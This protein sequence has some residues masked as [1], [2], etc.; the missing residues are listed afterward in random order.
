MLIVF[1]NARALPVGIQDCG[2][3]VRTDIVGRD[4]NVIF[5]CADTHIDTVEVQ[6]RYFKV[7]IG[8][9]NNGIALAA[10]GTADIV[11]HTVCLVHSAVGQ[12]RRAGVG[13]IVAGKEE[14]N[15]SRLNGLRQHF[16]IG[17]SAA[18]GIR[19]VYRNMG[20]NN[21]PGA[22][23]GGSIRDQPLLKALKTSLIHRVVQNGHINITVLYRVPVSGQI[24]DPLGGNSIV[25]VV[26]RLV[27]ADDMEEI[28]SGEAIKTEQVQGVFPFVVHTNVIDRVTQL[29]AE[30]VIVVADQ[31]GD[32]AE[33][34]DGILFLNISHQEEISL[35]VICRCGC[36]RPDLRPD[37]TIADLII[38]SGIGG[39][40]GHIHAVDPVC[41]IT[42]GI[43]DHRAGA[44]IDHSVAHI[45]I[46]GY[47]HFR[48]G[49]R[50]RRIAHPG[51]VLFRA[52]IG[53][54]IGQDVIRRSVLISCCCIA[55]NSNGEGVVAFIVHCVN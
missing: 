29:N 49:L 37:L 7:E 55:G 42:A 16:Q 9:V 31:I 19:V 21:F 33:T 34:V 23:R 27:V 11:Y 25:A 12:G 38:V 28:Q 35:N 6:R 13:M 40:A 17:F 18:G 43:A 30:I 26:I 41:H 48:L 47:A 3:T 50:S 5:I 52:R 45:R 20:D 36:E 1:A 44:G 2:S 10:G 54:H 53:Y 46:D 24:I 32:P 15:A 4:L 8:I 22:V 51:D 39:K 14:I